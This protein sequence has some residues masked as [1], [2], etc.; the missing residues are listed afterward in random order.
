MTGG[1]L[2]AAG[3]TIRFNGP[4]LQTIRTVSAFH[5][6][7]IAKVTGIVALSTP[8]TISGTL[9]FGNHVSFPNSRLQLLS[10]DLS[11]S[12]PASSATST[13]YIIAENTGSV[14]Q[15]ITVGS[16]RSFPVGTASTYLPAIIGLT[17]GTADQFRVR[18]I[19]SAFVTG[20]SGAIKNSGVVSATWEI[21]EG[22]VGGTSD[23]SVSFQWPQSSEF[24]FNRTLAQVARDTNGA[25]DYGP[26]LAASGNDPYSIT[27]TGFTA[28]SPFS[29]RMENEPLPVTWLHFSGKR[30]G[31]DNL[32]QW[33]T[34]AEQDNV[35]FE[36]QASTTGRQYTT[37]GRRAGALTTSSVQH[38]DFLHAGVTDALTH[39]RIRQTDLNGR[40][41]Y[42]RI[43]RVA[44]SLKA[45]P[46]VFVVT[47][48]VFSIATVSY[49]SSAA[50]KMYLTLSTVGGQIVEARKIS[51][52]AGSNTLAIDLKDY[53]TGVY[54]LKL[55][56]ESGHVHIRQLVKQ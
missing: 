1:T 29:V 7:S 8:A 22:L 19:S 13:N 5:N 2:T 16:S 3:S 4:S 26:V 41:S 44:A 54:F 18:V 17:A 11:L 37:I 12:N 33:S 42:S 6:L 52:K 46:L 49:L 20:S 38:Y 31:K 23:A 48:P 34:A 39:Y 53:S 25:W 40:V 28:F 27:R 56:D 43:V 30:V 9:S 55:T 15:P 36:V 47:N 32:L 45:E 35:A 10:H 21:A 50:G 14:I 51:M 24:G